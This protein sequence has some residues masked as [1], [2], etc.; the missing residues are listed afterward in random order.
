MLLDK[1]LV[2]VE[3]VDPLLQIQLLLV[4]EIVIAKRAVF[5]LADEYEIGQAIGPIFSLFIRE[6]PFPL[7]RISR[8]LR[9]HVLHCY[10]AVSGEMHGV[11]TQKVFELQQQMT[12]E[13]LFVHMSFNV[14][15]KFILINLEELFFLN[16]SST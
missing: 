16:N 8:V 7:T 9:Q 4:L 6:I 14:P 10:V 15:D 12:G 3:S 1:Y 2:G 5:L 13:L 11:V